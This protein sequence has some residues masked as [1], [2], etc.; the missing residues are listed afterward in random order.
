M[1]YITNQKFVELLLSDLQEKDDL[2]SIFF[3][4]QHL[5]KKYWNKIFNSDFS[6]LLNTVSPEVIMLCN[7]LQKHNKFNSNDLDSIIKLIKKEYPDYTKNVDIISLSLNTDLSD[8]IDE[9]LSK[10]FNKFSSNKL[11]WEEIW[12]VIKWDWNYYKR[13][14]NSDLDKLLK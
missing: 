10:K 8:K 1:S 3:V 12:I 2:L 7:L 9:V 14:L 13:S 6:E 4:C 11:K 5:F